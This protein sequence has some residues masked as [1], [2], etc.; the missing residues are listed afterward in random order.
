MS[1]GTDLVEFFDINGAYTGKLAG[2]PA[3]DAV[4]TEHTMM[5]L[6][7]A[8]TVLV[9]LGTFIWILVKSIKASNKKD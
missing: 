6:F 1:L 7:Y 2:T 4:M 9:F 3:M 8:S 5:F